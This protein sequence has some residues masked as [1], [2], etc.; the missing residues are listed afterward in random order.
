MLSFSWSGSKAIQLLFEFTMLIRKYKD[1]AIDLDF[2]VE[3]PIK[4]ISLTINTKYN[5]T[6]VILNMCCRHITAD[7]LYIH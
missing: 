6:F 7:K 2:N 3:L 1:V 5:I 4:F